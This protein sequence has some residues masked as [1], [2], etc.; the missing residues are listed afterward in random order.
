LL[1]ASTASAP[2]AP[3]TGKNAPTSAMDD[4]GDTR[5]VESGEVDAMGESAFRSS[6]SVFEPGEQRVKESRS[7][8]SPLSDPHPTDGGGDRKV[9]EGSGL[10]RK[11][12]KGVA[13]ND[14]G[15]GS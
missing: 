14:M 9:I 1:R 6:K 7:K 11:K 8:S 12:G 2:L 15:G 10:S 13:G 5:M 4:F 3:S